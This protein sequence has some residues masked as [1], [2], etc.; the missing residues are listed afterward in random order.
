MIAQHVMANHAP[1]VADSAWD[2]AENS[3]MGT[4]VGTVAASDPDHGQI[5][6]YAIVAGYTGGAFAIDAVTGVV[7]VANPAALDFETNPVITLTVQ[8]TDDGAPALSGSGQITIHLQHVNE[9]PVFM[10]GNNLMVLGTQGDDTIYLWSG[11][12]AQQA[13]A[14]MNGTMYGSFML[15]AGGRVIAQGGA[16]NDQIYA[17]DLHVGATIFGQGGN[18]QMTGGSAN[19]QLDGGDGNDKLWGGPGDD[20]IQG[21]AGDDCLNGWTGNDLLVG[22]AGND[23]LDGADGNDFLLGSLGSDQLAAAPART[24]SSAELPVT[25]TITL[26]WALILVSGFLRIASPPASICFPMACTTAFVSRI[27]ETVLDDE[28]PGLHGR[29]AWCRL[30]LRLGNDY[31]HAND[32]NDV[33]KLM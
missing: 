26:P 12:S 1:I 2:L 7:S 9:S 24:Y 14:W 3:V 21:G 20:K 25:T 22:G 10:S 29:G 11:S 6:S 27:G 23:Y 8:A 4:I 13:F 15:P 33:V 18:D 17:T 30:A 5:L 32:P 28:C 19:D 31:L 16:G